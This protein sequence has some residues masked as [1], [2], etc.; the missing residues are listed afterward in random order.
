MVDVSVLVCDSVVEVLEKH[1]LK[2]PISY[3]KN[4]QTS[5]E[6]AHHLMVKLCRHTGRK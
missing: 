4:S 1:G 3:V 5:E 6:E 2:K